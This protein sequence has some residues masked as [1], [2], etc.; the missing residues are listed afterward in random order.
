[1]NVVIVSVYYIIRSSLL[2]NTTPTTRG[3][4]VCPVV[5]LGTATDL[6]TATSSSHFGVRVRVA[7][8]LLVEMCE[9]FKYCACLQS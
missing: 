2:L 6:S 9:S 1:M 4:I 7:A 8:K 3:T 5:F